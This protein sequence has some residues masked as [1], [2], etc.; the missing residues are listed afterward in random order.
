MLSFQQDDS[1]IYVEGIIGIS[2]DS[3]CK[4]GQVMSNSVYYRY[5]FR[6]SNMDMISGDKSHFIEYCFKLNHYDLTIPKF[7]QTETSHT[8]FVFLL[9][10]DKSFQLQLGESIITVGCER[11][12]INNVFYDY[13]VINKARVG[14]C[15]E[16]Y[17]TVNEITRQCQ[18]NGEWE[19]ISNNMICYPQS[20]PIITPT[21]SD[22]S[23]SFSNDNKKIILN[24]KI[25]LSD[26][27]S[28]IENHIDNVT[29]FYSLSHTNDKLDS[30][31]KYKT[32][33][34][35][36]E[37]GEISF[38]FEIDNNDTTID[39]LVI[40]IYGNEK[41]QHKLGSVTYSIYIYI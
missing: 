15:V 16:F 12:T 4:F 37:N 10:S 2:D 23:V 18:S 6:P 36:F 17:Y 33:P 8:K 5:Y 29:Y 39:K 7:S 28:C 21:A 30:N 11:I 9:Y 13:T 20:M 34:Y 14:K 40:Q 41:Q 1:F 19:D 22:L 26:G 35:C 27:S 32:I 25:K 31:M 38:D 3:K 24:G